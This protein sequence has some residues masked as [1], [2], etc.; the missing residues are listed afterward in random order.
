MS[1]Q[2]LH[3]GRFHAVR[4]GVLLLSLCECHPL[5]CAVGSPACDVARRGPGSF[6]WVLFSGLLLS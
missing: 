6:T 3:W 5:S 1:H 2:S 4:Q